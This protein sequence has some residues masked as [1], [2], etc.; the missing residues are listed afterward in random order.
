M[1]TIMYVK[2]WLPYNYQYRMINDSHTVYTYVKIVLLQNHVH[3]NIVWTRNIN[4]T[5]A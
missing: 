1:S 3:E 4:D 5:V 2:D